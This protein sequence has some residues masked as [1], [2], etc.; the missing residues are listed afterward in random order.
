MADNFDMKKFLVENKLG[1]YSKLKETEEGYM[2]TQYDSSEDMAVDMMKK[3]ITEYEVIYVVQN[4]RCYRKDDEGNMDEVSMSKCRQYAEGKKEKSLNEDAS[5]VMDVLGML[6]G[7]AGMGLTGVQILKWQNKLEKENPELYKQLGKVGTT[8][9]G[10]DPS[11]NLEESDD[12]VEEGTINEYTGSE[13]SLEI[14]QWVIDNYPQVA[15]VLKAKPFGDG[16]EIVDLGNAVVGLA[17]AG[18]L[19]LGAGLAMFGDSIVNAVKDA[20]GKLK[21]ALSKVG[22]NKP[23]TSIAEIYEDMQIDPELMS[24]AAK[25]KAKGMNEEKVKEALSPEAFERMDGLVSQ[26]DIMEY[27]RAAER[28]V[29]TLS[30]EGFE[31]RDIFDYL[32]QIV[33]N[34]L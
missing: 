27:L 6:A 3:G 4:G 31:A 24:L 23:S 16:Q 29:N 7:L 17:T 25:I 33:I 5:A 2:G 28:I 21:S 1:A 15:D 11:K 26:S 18:T 14:G 10:A 12:T 30:D 34:D 9:G 22:S 19:T 13:L 8:I 20:A 32:H